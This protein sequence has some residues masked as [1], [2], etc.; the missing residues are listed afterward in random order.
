ML[1]S[2]VMQFNALPEKGQRKRRNKKA[3]KA[4][5]GA[6]EEEEVPDFVKAFAKAAAA[7]F[8]GAGEAPTKQESAGAGKAMD[9]DTLK[10]NGSLA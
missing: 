3:R 1:I 7:G 5:R 9:E 8:E 10:R 4:P 6:E 2:D